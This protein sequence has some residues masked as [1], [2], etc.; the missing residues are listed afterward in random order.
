MYH[1]LLLQRH[2]SYDA[3]IGGFSDAD[4]IGSVLLRVRDLQPSQAVT[5]A[6]SP[7]DSMAFRS[8]GSLNSS[9][10]QLRGLLGNLTVRCLSREQASWPPKEIAHFRNAQ[11]RLEVTKLPSSVARSTTKGDL[12]DEVLLQIQALITEGRQQQQT[13]N[14]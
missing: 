12:D 11:I 7:N 1:Q 2:S 3:S 13:V 6:L 4:R 5:V 10:D 8:P 14:D 9:K